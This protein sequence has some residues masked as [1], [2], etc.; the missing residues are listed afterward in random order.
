MLLHIRL[1]L[2]SLKTLR[3]AQF[4]LRPQAMILTYTCRFGS[5][6][7]LLAAHPRQHPSSYIR[8]GYY[9]ALLGGSVRYRADLYAVTKRE[10]LINKDKTER[11]NE[12]RDVNSFL[13]AEVIRIVSVTT[14]IRLHFPPELHKFSINLEARG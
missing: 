6:Q 5:N 8:A 3:Q 7:P 4:R 9:A 14:V 12:N 13:A 10:I 1:L 2:P 11:R